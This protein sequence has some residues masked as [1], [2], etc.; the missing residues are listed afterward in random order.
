MFLLV[1]V[2]HVGAHPGEHQHGVF[3]E[4]S[5]SLGQEKGGREATTGNASA[6]RRLSKKV[7]KGRTIRKLMG[8]GGRLSKYKKKFAQGKI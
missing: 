5:I 1:S 7:L 2:C 8:G 3:I 6:I 4:I